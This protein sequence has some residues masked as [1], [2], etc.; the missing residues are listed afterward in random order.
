VA[1]LQREI[2][3]LETDKGLLEAECD[4]APGL[5]TDDLLAELRRGI[6]EASEGRALERLKQLLACVVDEIVVEG[7]ADHPRI[8]SR[9]VFL[10]RSLRGGG[11]ESNPPASS[12]RHTGFEVRG[13]SCCLV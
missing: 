12:R 4:R 8:S 7:A 2:V 5:P 1:L 11:R 6:L 10:C 13:R 3:S 9:R